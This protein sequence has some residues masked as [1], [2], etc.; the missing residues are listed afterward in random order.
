[1]KKSGASKQRRKER[2]DLCPQRE[3]G[4]S[5]EITNDVALPLPHAVSPEL[6]H[7]SP[8]LEASRFRAVRDVFAAFE[9][10]AGQHIGGRK[11]HRHFE[12]WL[13]SRRE[14]ARGK[15]QQEVEERTA[16]STQE[17][18]RAKGKT[19]PVV[20]LLPKTTE[21]DPSLVSKLE[22]T[23]VAHA[24]ATQIACSLDGACR[25]AFKKWVKPLKAAHCEEDYSDVPTV[26]RVTDF[27]QSAHPPS[28]IGSQSSVA[29]TFEIRFEDLRFQIHGLHLSRL[30]GRWKTAREENS[31]SARN[32][33]KPKGGHPKGLTNRD[34]REFV[35]AVFCLLARYAAAAGSPKGGAD[36][37]ACP[38]PAFQTMQTHWKVTAECFA[39]AFNSR[40][41]SFCSAFPDTDLPFG[42]LGSFFDFKPLEGSFEANPPFVPS[43]VSQMAKHMEFLLSKAEKRKKALS[44]LVVLP[45]WGSSEKSVDTGK[46]EAWGEVRH[47]RFCTHCESLPANTHCFTLGSQHTSGQVQHCKGGGVLAELRPAVTGTDLI[48]LQTQA[49]A[50]LWPVTAGAVRALVASFASPRMIT[51]SGGR[52]VGASKGGGKVMDSDGEKE[53]K[54]WLAALSR[55]LL[56]SNYEQEK[57]DKEVKEEKFAGRPRDGAI[58]V[59]KGEKG[60][61]HGGEEAGSKKRKR[62]RGPEEEEGGEKEF[63]KA[64]KRSEE[65]VEQGRYRGSLKENKRM[66]DPE[67]GSH[68]FS[69]K[70]QNLG[71]DKKKKRRG[72]MDLSRQKQD[73]RFI[74]KTDSFKEERRKGGSV[75]PFATKTFGQKK[76]TSPTKPLK[77][78]W[79][80]GK[81]VKER[82]Q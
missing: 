43:V 15:D 6:K 47:S 34:A 7:P 39:S 11:V 36:Q 76:W 61:S 17:S 69:E 10:T 65:Q 30:F 45:S 5:P 2:Q 24:E 56:P 80:S 70:N 22:A 73:P 41:P 26:H 79:S 3:R 55:L 67:T 18:L 27:S 33:S 50:A 16:E 75:N 60:A 59:F 21:P 82:S 72:K 53:S 23:G 29:Q 14:A 74:T 52:G 71:G 44:F 20:P 1:M 78:G 35:S 38:N 58:Q 28:Q 57:G 13:W 49:A 51:Q 48:W 8:A 81:K 42:S 12:D 54:E 62:T 77:R 4:D 68:F 19:D 37:A 46:R 9:D 32:E 63:V 40:L 66:K 25:R 64:R 31:S